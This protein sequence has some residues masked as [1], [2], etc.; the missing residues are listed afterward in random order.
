MQ[1]SYFE[2]QQGNGV[3]ASLLCKLFN[4]G[5]EGKSWSLI[6]RLYQEA[7][8]SVKWN[9]LLSD[10]FK[11]EQ[12]VRQGGILSADFYKLYANNALLRVDKSGYGASIGTVFCGAPACADDMLFAT[13][14]PDE[15]QQMLDMALDYSSMENYLLQP[16][17]SVIVVAEPSKRAVYNVN[18]EWNLGGVPKPQV[19]STT[20]MGMPRSTVKFSPEEVTMNIQKARRS[21]YSLMPAGLHGE[22]GLDPLTAMHV[23]QIY[24]LPVLLYGLEVAVPSKTNLDILE[25][26]LRTSL[27]QILSLPTSTVSPAVYILTGILPCG[28]YDPQTDTSTIWKHLS[29]ERGINRET[30]SQTTVIDKVLQ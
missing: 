2:L 6:R 13:D 5:I 24:V 1:C 23:F 4:I 29:T 22:N 17:K 20:H 26:F 14:D 12:G 21:M 3:T 16:V 25:R 19:T 18:R 28:S 15:L 27:K 7:V 8:S 10:Q 11:V 30:T 9:G